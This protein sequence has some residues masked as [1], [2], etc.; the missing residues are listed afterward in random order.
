MFVTSRGHRICYQVFGAG[1]AV[2]LLH[3]HP[4][5]GGRWV[6]RGYVDGLADRFT[7]IVPDLLGHGDSDKPHNPAAYGDPNIAADV[8]AV[9]DRQ[10]VQ[11]AHVWGYSWGSSV[12][13]HLAVAAPARVLSLVL[14][15]FPIGLNAARRAEILGEP[16]ASIE[17]MFAGWPPALAETYIAKNDFTAIQAW[18]QAFAQFPV[19][20]D[21][22]RA[23]PHPTLA[24]YGADDTYLDLARQQAQALPCRFEQVPGD[25]VIAFA[26]P[27]SILPA[28]IAHTTAAIPAR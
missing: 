7:V 3:G 5:W 26:Q 28:A 17:E 23:A 19:T 8:L 24:Y 27:A 20:I 13:E 25:H 14:G 4:M 22:L 16:P 12:A 15:G 1:P 6:D 18:H 2:V 9:L 11:A 21:Q 10:G